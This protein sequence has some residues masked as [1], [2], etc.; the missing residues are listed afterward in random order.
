MIRLLPT[1]MIKRLYLIFIIIGSIVTVLFAYFV[2]SNTKNTLIS[3][4]KLKLLTITTV[5]EQKLP[6]SYEKILKSKNALG[7]TA[8]EKRR[9]LNQ[10]LQP[11]IDE[12]AQQYPGYSI[13]YYSPDLNIIA[14]H[15]FNSESLGKE[16]NAKALTLYN[17]KEMVI[18]FYDSSNS[19]LSVCYPLFYDKELIG[20]VWANAKA[21]DIE[22]EII[23]S[24]FKSVVVVLLFFIIV[25]GIMKWVFIKMDSG[26]KILVEQI[27]AGESNPQKL[28][29]FPRLIPI[30]KIID[31][32]REK[33]ARNLWENEK[34]KEKNIRLERLN[35]I[36]KIACGVAH[37]IRNPLQVVMGYL[38]F[39]SS[40]AEEKK[41]DQFSVLLEE[42]DHINKLITDFLFLARDK[43]VEKEVVQLNDI[44]HDSLLLINPIA[45]IKGININLK[46]DR[47][48]PELT[49]DQKEIKQLIFN[50]MQNAIQSMGCNG[51]VTITT[52]SQLEKV[53]LYISDTGSG[54]CKEHLENIFDPFFTTKDN[55][56]GLGLSVCK[57][58]IERHQ[59]EITVESREGIGTMFIVTFKTNSY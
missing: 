19:M 5:L 15:P 29:N 27:E 53:Q 42:L 9:I 1:T 25:A 11:V 13:G 36:S 35:L 47:K 40:K 2:A 28:R 21:E 57:S 38:Q 10:Y 26:L 59:G 8:E 37:E 3:K 23:V 54:I 33:E 31:E 14:L 44:I 45:F 16:A 46:L 39:M 4:E 18:D 41:K 30:I 6:L 52:V 43:R 22:T 7:A 20:H 51:I 58:I 34:I 24:V 55:A 49:L 56:T 12:V 17:T 50:L 48:L 32:L